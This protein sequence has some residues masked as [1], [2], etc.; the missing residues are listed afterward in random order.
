M[1]TVGAWESRFC[2][3]LHLRVPCGGGDISMVLNHQILL[4][5][6]SFDAADSHLRSPR[7]NVMVDI[8]SLDLQFLSYLAT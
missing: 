6:S 5:G 7:M 4:G 2:T 1:A 8:F 3:T